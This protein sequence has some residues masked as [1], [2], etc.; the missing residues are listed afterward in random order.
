M[1]KGLVLSVLFILLSCRCRELGECAWFDWGREAME[2]GM[3]C[4]SGKMARKKEP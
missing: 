1:A 3:A 2:L 4:V